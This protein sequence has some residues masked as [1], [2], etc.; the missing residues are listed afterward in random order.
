[1]GELAALQ[2][3]VPDRA[4]Q[5]VVDKNMFQKLPPIVQMHASEVYKNITTDC[6]M[7]YV[8][9]RNYPFRGLETRT[10]EHNPVPTCTFQAWDSASIQTNA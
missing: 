9:S 4:T 5:I 6:Q 7:D 2:K 1:M 8:K 3:L 10:P